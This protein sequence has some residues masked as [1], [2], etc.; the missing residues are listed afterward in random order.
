M[1][2]EGRVV[3]VLRRDREGGGDV[4]SDPLEPG[5]LR[6][7]KRTPGVLLGEK[8]RMEALVDQLRIRNQLVLLLEGKANERH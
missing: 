2:D 7:R 8:P 5:N 4:V 6:R 1:L 3:E